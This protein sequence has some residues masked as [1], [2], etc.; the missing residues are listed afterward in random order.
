MAS[1]SDF[2]VRFL[3]VV[4]VFLFIGALIT[5]FSNDNDELTDFFKLL[6][7]T[8][9][10]KILVSILY[11]RWDVISKQQVLPTVLIIL[12]T[13]LTVGVVVDF[14]IVVERLQ[15]S[16]DYDW[17]TDYLTLGLTFLT[18][19]Q[20]LAIYF[21]FR[22]RRAFFMTFFLILIEFSFFATVFVLKVDA[23]ID[24]GNLVVSMVTASLSLYLWTGKLVILD[25]SSAQFYDF[26]ELKTT[27]VPSP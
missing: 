2:L 16:S 12:C 22:S 13:I 18:D 3:L 6:L 11:F 25:A 23:A 27:L 8:L 15:G 14:V 10:F 5:K 4:S 19:L 24:V 21:F 9:N 26:H 7:V 1:K 20:L 17:R